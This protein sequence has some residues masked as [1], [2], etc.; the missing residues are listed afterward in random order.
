MFAAHGN[1]ARAYAGVAV[2]TSVAAAAPVDLVV[3]LYE[4]AMDGIVKAVGH[5]R[6]RNFEAKGKQVTRV[7]RI[8]EEGLRGSLDPRGGDVSNN[9]RDLYDYM[10]I[11]LLQGSVKNDPAILIEVRDLLADIK[12][13][14]DELAR[15][16]HAN[17]A[18]AHAAA[19]LAA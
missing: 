17:A 16:T 5:M 10:A 3:M 4:G 6:E 18:K 14:W 9:L 1:P 7:I 12:G 15:T 2:E 8:L 19:R 13:A 11:R